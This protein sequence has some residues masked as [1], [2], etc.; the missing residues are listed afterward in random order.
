M[1][2]KI[3]E[4]LKTIF[5]IIIFLFLILFW[6]YALTHREDWGGVGIL[7]FSIWGYL[8]FM[9]WSLKKLG[10]I[11]EEVKETLE[12]KINRFKKIAYKEDISSLKKLINDSE[13][14]KLIQDKKLAS[15][16]KNKR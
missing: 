12:E 15:Y 2:E 11:E 13:K 4:I 5:G 1:K 14:E 8:S 7:I 6:P 3:K 16:I 10:I 9:K